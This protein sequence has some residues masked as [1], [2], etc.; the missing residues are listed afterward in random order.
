M[1]T[2]DLG[3]RPLPTGPTGPAKGRTATVAAAELVATSPA[4]LAAAG[5][6]RL[7]VDGPVPAGR[8]VD[9]DLR[10]LRFLRAATGQTLRVEWTLGGRPLVSLRDVVHL[11]PP[12]DGA[13]QDAAEYAAAWRADYRYG[14]YYYRQG[15]GFVTVKDVRPGGPTVHLTIDGDSAVQFRAL[16]A[17]TTVAELDADSAA[18]LTDAV[19]YGLVL[20]G[21]D[22]LLMLPFR[23]RQWPVPYSAV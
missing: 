23:M 9:E 3:L 7:V 1:T 17:A 12:V 21:A 2:T 6:E 4:E 11:V 13:G 20:R 22:T 18:A 8:D 14:T 5:Y 10:L 19:D 16:A 15:P